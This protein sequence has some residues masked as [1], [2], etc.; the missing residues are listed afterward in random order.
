[1]KLSNVLFLSAFV[2][3]TA[4]ANPALAQEWTPSIS[5]VLVGCVTLPKII[6]SVQVRFNPAAGPVNGLVYEFR[7]VS[8]G[9]TI[10]SAQ[11][12]PSGIE[13]QLPP[14]TY[15]LTVKH[16]NSLHSRSQWVNI[17]VPVAV[18]TN[19][20]GTGCRF[21]GPGEMPAGATPLKR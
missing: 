15:D 4:T 2:L 19:A 14:G 11:G 20:Q 7:N 18:S 10:T 21:L 3:G 5:S 1:M 17:V 16:L 9:Q 8:A 6:G 13:V 12:D